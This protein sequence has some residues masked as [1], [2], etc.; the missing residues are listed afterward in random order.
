MTEEK[1][2]IRMQLGVHERGEP[3]M[4]FLD[5][6]Q[7]QVV[8]AR[9]AVKLQVGLDHEVSVPHRVAIDARLGVKEPVRRPADPPGSL[10]VLLVPCRPVEAEQRA[11]HQRQVV[12]QLAALDL[13]GGDDLAVVKQAILR[14]ERARRPIDDLAGPVDERRGF[15]AAESRQPQSA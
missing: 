15:A 3:F 11:E 10:Q 12:C 6:K 8:L 14:L 13:A 5:T 7:K 4:D 1:N 2:Y 9:G